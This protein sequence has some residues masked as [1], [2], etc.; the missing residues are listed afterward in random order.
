V[1]LIKTEILEEWRNCY[2]SQ[3]TES[4]HPD[5][6]GNTFLQKVLQEP[7]GVTSKKMAFFIVTVVETSNLT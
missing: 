5:D 2:H 7:H 3:L 6:G 1:A 4:F